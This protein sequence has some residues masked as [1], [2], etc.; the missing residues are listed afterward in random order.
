MNEL[1]RL[2]IEDIV[3]GEGFPWDIMDGFGRLLMR[4]GT[5]VKNQAN[6]Q[7]MIARGMYIEKS[8]YTKLPPV[9]KNRVSGSSKEPE[10]MLNTEDF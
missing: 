2:T 8:L 4:Q 6:V 1:H 9:D 3:L 10:F 7:E 5:S